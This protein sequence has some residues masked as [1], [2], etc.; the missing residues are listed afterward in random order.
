MAIK[1][2]ASHF[3]LSPLEGYRVRRQPAE[4]RS[5]KRGGNP[6]GVNWSVIAKAAPSSPTRRWLATGRQGCC[7]SRVVHSV[8]GRWE[9]GGLDGQPSTRPKGAGVEGSAPPS[10]G[11]AATLRPW[12]VGVGGYLKIV[13]LGN[14]CWSFFTPLSVTLVPTS[15]TTWR[16]PDP[17]RYSSPASV[18]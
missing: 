16:L 1:G 15:P 2:P 6:I 12:R 8:W 7:P 5:L 9:G 13:E 11:C 18:I 14:A 17:L 4:F 3:R 10:G